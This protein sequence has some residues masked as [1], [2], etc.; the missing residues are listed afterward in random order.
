MKAKIVKAT[1]P[2]TQV[3]ETLQSKGEMEVVLCCREKRKEVVERDGWEVG[4]D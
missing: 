4:S 1:Y 3:H 2:C